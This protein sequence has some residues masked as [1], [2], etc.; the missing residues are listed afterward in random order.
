MS[1]GNRIR[2]FFGHGVI[3]T[4]LLT[5]T[6]II[7]SLTSGFSSSSPVAMQMLAVIALTTAIY[8]ILAGG[9]YAFFHR[10]LEDMGQIKMMFLMTFLIWATFQIYNIIV[11]LFTGQAL[12]SYV[13]STTD[14][15]GFLLN[16]LYQVVGAVIYL[17]ILLVLLG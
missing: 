9:I 12:R 5:L 14:V 16:W 6:F 17:L 2:Q 15:A 3:A 1:K 8:G 7:I 13:I 10:K 11:A 4:M